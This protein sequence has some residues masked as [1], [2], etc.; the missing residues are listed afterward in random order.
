[1]R[2]AVMEGGAWLTLEDRRLFPYREKVP[3][4]ATSRRGAICRQAG[5]DLTLVAAGAML[6]AA[7]RAV[8]PLLTRGIE[9]EVIDL[10]LLAPLDVETLRGSLFRTHRALVIDEG[11]TPMGPAVV[12]ALTDAAFDELDAP[13]DLLR[14]PAGTATL[15]EALDRAVP[16]IVTR[17]CWLLGRPAHRSS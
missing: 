7:L 11:E 10:R 16:A 14:V 15:A 8:R 2:R 3:H 1:M 12:A 13:V 17:A 6:L 5:S 9:A 4:P